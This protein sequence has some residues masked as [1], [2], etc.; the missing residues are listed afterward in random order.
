MD[1]DNK[2][3]MEVLQDAEATTHLQHWNVGFPFFLQLQ[4]Q[5]NDIVPR[6]GGSRLGKSGNKNRHRDAGRHAAA[7]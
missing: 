5:L 1:S 2:I 3:M 4:Q 7:L 6:R